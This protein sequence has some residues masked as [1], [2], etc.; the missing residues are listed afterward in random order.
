MWEMLTAIG[1]IASAVVIAVTVLMAARQVRLTADQ[2]EELRRATQFQGAMAIFQEQTSHVFWGG[3]RFVMTELKERM[4]DESFRSEVPLVG[5]ADDTVHKEL[6]ILRTFDNIGL[7]VKQRLIEPEVIYSSPV[8]VRAILGW[9]ALQDVIAIH[10][11][12]LGP[13]MWGNYEYLYLEGKRWAE[14]NG[15][16]LDLASVVSRLEAGVGQKA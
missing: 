4:T 15:R 11:Q 7:Y 8:F 5:M 1:T 10:R 6:V 9:E 2:L 13:W 16:T 3:I 14:R 12:S